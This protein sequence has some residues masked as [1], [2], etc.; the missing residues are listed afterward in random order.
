MFGQQQI[1]NNPS[2]SHTFA[3]FV[4]A[5]WPGS[6]PCRTAPCLEVCTISWLPCNMRLRALALRPEGGRR[7]DL[8]TTLH[9]ALAND[10]RTSLWGP[11][12]IHPELY[13]RA[14]RQAALL[15]SGQ[16]LFKVNDLGHRGDQVSNCIHAVS[17]IVDGNPVHVAV[18]G[19]GE[20][21]SYRV[22]CRMEPWIIQGH[23]VHT[24]VA[25][26]LGLDRYPIIYRDWQNPQISGF[27]GP[28]GRLLGNEWDLQPT[29]G[30][31]VW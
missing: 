14:L 10:M 21:A 11:Y 25:S 31:P 23:V 22:L 28:I 30:P 24:W 19:W 18:P 20:T 29:Y 13:Q 7:F 5:S 1:P 9:W 12:Q 26:A 8:Y 16:V 3:M 2:Y 15:E 17:N 27:G 6:N 4:R